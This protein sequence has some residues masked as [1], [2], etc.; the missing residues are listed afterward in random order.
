MVCTYPV[1][2]AAHFAAVRGV[3]APGFRIVSA[4]QCGDLTLVI[5]DDL[6]A[7]NEVTPAKTDL[8]AGCHA[9][10]PPRRVLHE[11]IAIDVQ[12]A[13]ERDRTA[14]CALI[15]RIVYGIEPFGLAFGVVRDHDREWIENSHHARGGK[16]QLLANE[17]FQQLDLYSAVGAG[18][19]DVLT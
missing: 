7:A 13:T 18:D 14:A 8:S 9:M 17:V 15:L 11:I 5:P 3:A 1:D 16:V 2:R 6:L 12:V 19:S 10:E 4:V